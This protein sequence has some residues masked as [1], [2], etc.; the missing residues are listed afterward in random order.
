MRLVIA[1]GGN[2]LLQ[3]GEVLSA[4]NQE[5]NMQLAAGALTKIAE[6]NE[7][8]LVH[9]NGPQVGLLA[10][11]GEAFKEAPAFPLDV[12][13]AESQGMIGYVIG[14]VLHNAMP[15]RKIV[16]VLTRT[17]V[18]VT[19]PAFKNPTKPIGPIYSEH[20]ANTLARDRG[21]DITKED[22]N[23]RRVVPSPAPADILEL[24]I[25]EGL[26][27]SGVLVICGGGGG[28]PVVRKAD[29]RVSGV[30]AVVDKDLT[31]ALLAQRLNADR[32]L[33]L[34]DVDGVYRNWGEPDEQRL[35]RVTTN[36]LDDMR[37]APGSMGPKVDAA[38][39]FAKATGNPA[40]IGSLQDADQIF[41]GT[42][43][44]WITSE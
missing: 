14:Q 15:N 28:I 33:I 42:K 4:E 16:T 39:N 20:D 21:W 43:G 34:T 23:F 1:I 22:Q 38:S 35:E 31:A 5:R 2:A 41:A 10:L 8:I 13:G 44:T 32:L 12:L 3:R 27:A 37:F 19:D 6:G 40:L 9:G 29:G 36:A 18:D 11:E 30:E 25:V 24:P 26:V 17:L 7:V